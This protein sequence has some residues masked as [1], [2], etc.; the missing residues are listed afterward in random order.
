MTAVQPKTIVIRTMP[1]KS[2]T[3]L[4][5]SSQL[6]SDMLDDLYGD[7]TCARKRR[8]LTHLSAEEKMLRRYA[9]LQFNPDIN[10]PRQD[11]GLPR[12]EVEAF[13][14]FTLISRTF[15]SKTISVVVGVAE[16]LN[17]LVRNSFF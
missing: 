8:R 12:V 1:T 5:V 15:L 3:T 9:F 13:Q 10:W 4:T 14:N 17:F 11:I 2:A 6:E 16:I 7:G